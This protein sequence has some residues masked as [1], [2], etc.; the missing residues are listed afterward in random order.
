MR[1]FSYARS[2]LVTWQ[3]WRLYHSIRRTQKNHIAGKRHGSMFDRT[4]VIADR[5]FTL[6]E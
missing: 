3:R 2:L 6:W 1:A 4:G 5:S